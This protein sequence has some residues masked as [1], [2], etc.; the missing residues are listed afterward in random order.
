MIL[1]EGSVEIDF[2]G[3]TNAW[4]PEDVNLELQGM[5][6]V[7]FI[8]EYQNH[9]WLVEVKDFQTPKKLPK[10]E[11][12]IREDWVPKARDTYTYLHLMAE[13]TKPIDYLV[14]AEGVDKRLFPKLMEY[15]E[16]RIIK[17]ADRPWKRR[18]VRQCIV[19]DI[20]EAQKRESHLGFKV[21]RKS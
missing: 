16:S 20:A 7:D 9:Y 5:S 10:Y 8:A 2:V 14:I 19:M 3:A 11:A 21:S 1:M 6:K 4:K 15:L 18:Y 12:K 13:D 17:E